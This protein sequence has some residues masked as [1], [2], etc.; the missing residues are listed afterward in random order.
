VVLVPIRKADLLISN[1]R[2]LFHGK[3]LESGMAVKDGLI[4]KFGKEP[5][6][7]PSRRR[8]DCGGRLVLPGAIDAHVHLRDQQLSYKETFETGTAAAVSGGVTTV[9]DMPNNEPPTNTLSNLQERERLAADRIYCNVGFFGA[10][11]LNPRETSRLLE[12]DAFG[13]KVNMLKPIGRPLTGAGITE[14]MKIAKFRD[15]ATVFHAELG[16][17]IRSVKRRLER[18]GKHTWDDFLVA[19]PPSSEV[20]A[21]EKA[22][23][24]AKTSGGRAHVAHVS[25]EGSVGGIQAAKKAG[26]ITTSEV[27]PHHL[28]LDSGKLKELE[29]LGIMTPP[30]RTSKDCKALREALADGRIDICASDHA[31]HS[32]TEKNSDSVWNISP[33]V[34]GLD[35]FMPLLLTHA[36]SWGIDF[37]RLAEV[38]SGKPAEIF[39]VQKR[40]SLELGYYAD[41]IVVDTGIRQ[42]IRADDFKSK[43]K[44]SPFDGWL[45]TAAVAE[46]YVGGECV[47]S[48]GEIIGK[49]QG[50]VLRSLR[51]G[52][53]ISP[54]RHAG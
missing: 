4:L 40:G 23:V 48:N 14:A 10:P 54:R 35:T 43:A 2:I 25:C 45:L 47:F 52:I 11:N 42:R 17:S 15:K 38:T 37:R 8:V 24:Y 29:G 50:S 13:L 28:L 18:L 33:G 44:F 53:E 5:E 3:I 21:T 20:S 51:D 1:A 22:L 7:P 19:H 9:L 26:L 46:T 32:W 34:S 41:F 39:R 12:N 6:L 27:T 31:P 49:P 16:A 36:V 30:L